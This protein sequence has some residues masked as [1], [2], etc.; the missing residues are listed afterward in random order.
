[1]T[2]DEIIGLE[3]E[4][5]F[6]VLAKQAFDNAYAP[7]P[8]PPPPYRNPR[9]KEFLRSIS[10]IAP[11][12]SDLIDPNWSFQRAR[13]NFPKQIPELYNQL[14]ERVLPPGFSVQRGIDS[15]LGPAKWLFNEV[16]QGVLPNEAIQEIKRDPMSAASLGAYANAAIMLSRGAGGKGASELPRVPIPE[17]IWN[18]TSCREAQVTP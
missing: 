16:R 6:S 10:P 17:H 11:A 15:A 7:P 14:K 5:D 2:F 4:P 18:T 8:P 1:M 3:P 12:L 9:D 13:E